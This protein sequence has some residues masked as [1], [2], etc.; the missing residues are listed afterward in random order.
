MAS[1]QEH[2]WIISLLAILLPAFTIASGQEP[3]NVARVVVW[4][5][6]AGVGRDFEEGYKRH[7]EWHRQNSDSWTWIGWTLVSGERNGYFIDGTFSHAWKDLDAPVSPSADA[8]NNAI[9]VFPYGDVR[10]ASIYES[11]PGLT[12]MSAAQ[13]AEPLLNFCTFEV[14]P[15]RAAQF[16]LLLENALQAASTDN[17]QQHMLLRPVNGTTDYLLLLP[18]QKPSN[19]AAQARFTA[20]LLETIV[21][22]TQGASVIRGFRT[23]IARYRPEMSYRPDSNSERK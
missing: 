5:P 20:Q 21:Q 2:K 22:K 15:G 8:A 16:E 14:Q 17:A 18:A 10:S 7:L 23:E 6:K 11:V 9:N 1:A 3:Q 19:L 4:Q 12:N 13:L